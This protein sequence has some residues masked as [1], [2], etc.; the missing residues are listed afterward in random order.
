MYRQPEFQD[1]EKHINRMK[2]PS[3]LAEC[4]GSLH[5]FDIIKRVKVADGQ[6]M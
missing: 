5:G 3:E 2:R 1:L 6:K 4:F